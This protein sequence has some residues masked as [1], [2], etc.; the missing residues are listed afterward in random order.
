MTNG[1]EDRG[2][3]A[4]LYRRL[5]GAPAVRL[6]AVALVSRIHA[7]PLL[8]EFF[9]GTNPVPLIEQLERFLS[10]IMGGPGSWRGPTPADA[11]AHFAVT[12]EHFDRVM[13]L[14]TQI[15]S[16]MALSPPL[17]DELEACIASLEPHLVNSVSRP[18][19]PS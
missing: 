3:G 12:P 19:L 6:F 1:G 11:V 14:V 16:E 13:V 18:T 4:P 9:S 10:V 15:A 17:L 7:D 2:L 5:G 8:G